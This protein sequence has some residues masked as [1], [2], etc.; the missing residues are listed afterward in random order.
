LF[1]A[2]LD[3][4]SRRAIDIREGETIDAS[5]LRALVKAAVTRN[6][7][8]VE[9]VE[10]AVK[11]LSG[12]NPQIAKGDGDARVAGLYRGDAGLEAR[13]R[14]AARRADRTDRARVRKAVKW[15]SPFYG[16]EGQGFF[17]G[18]HCMTKYVK[19]A[20]FRGAS[21]R[22]IPP[23]RVQAEGRA[24]L[25]YSTRTTVRRGA[26]GELGEAGRRA[27]RLGSEPKVL[28]PCRH[29]GQ[30]VIGGGLGGVCRWRGA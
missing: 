26:D 29:S 8:A 28:R 4:N 27:A 11:L 22:P 7:R 9:E 23:G 18:L 25:R 1:N 20:F 19:V 14:P 10:A 17:L 13:P 16:V 5:A 2:S 24:L 21:L 30:S 12:G 3:G 15:N 6:G